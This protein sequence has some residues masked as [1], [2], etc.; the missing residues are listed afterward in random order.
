MGKMCERA[1]LKKMCSASLMFETNDL[2]NSNTY[3]VPNPVFI[4]H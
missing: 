4:S 2:N 1:L 3:I